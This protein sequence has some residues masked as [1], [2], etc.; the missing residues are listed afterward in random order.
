MI[1]HC[2][3][4]A[5]ILFSVYT[6]AQKTFVE[7]SRIVPGHTNDVNLV[8]QTL[9]GDMIAT[10]SWDKN[11]NIYD[12]SFNLLRTLSG[13][14]FPLTALKFR[15]DGKL[16]ASGSSDNSIVI[17]DSLWRRSRQLDGHKDQ[18]NS[19]WFDK[20]N[21]YLFSG[22]DDR[23]MIA[24]DLASGKAFRTIDVGQSVN[25]ITQTT[26]P[27]FI[28]VASAGPQ[29][30]Q[31][32]LSNSTIARTFDGH[33]DVVNVIAVSLNNK[34]MISG[35]NDKTARIWDLVTGK[36]IRVLP[37]SC[38]KVTAVAF[39]DDSKYAVTGCNDGSIK[40]WEVETG[41]LVSQIEANGQAVKDL[42][43]TKNKQFV[44][45]AVMLRGSTNY[46]LR[47]W[48]SGIEAPKKPTLPSDTLNTQT[49]TGAVKKIV[50]AKLPAKNNTPQR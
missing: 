5:S 8:T 20:S 17:W 19:L 29:I 46:G 32:N 45:A 26:D 44:Y 12:T 14:T 16:L 27:R 41:K 10:G 4:S 21:K 35:S 34:W 22:G 2:L 47:V 3:L 36:P 31:Y 48:Q 23:M 24:W 18:V 37:V 39:S 7:P 25:C 1:K 30:K 38:W 15:A 40:V 33:A 6:Q 9:R 13:H 43:F 42:Q 49:D 11:I 28:Y 50:P